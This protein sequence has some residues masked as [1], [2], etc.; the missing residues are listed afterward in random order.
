MT[1]ELAKFT[2]ARR[3]GCTARRHPHRHAPQALH[4]AE[5]PA[6]AWSSCPAPTTCPARRQPPARGR[7][8]EFVT[9]GPVGGWSR[10]ALRTSSATSATRPA[11]RRGLATRAGASLLGAHDRASNVDAPATAAGAVKEHRRRVLADVR[12]PAV[13]RGALRARPRR[14]AR[15]SGQSRMR[16]GLHA[17]E[18]E[19]IGDDIGGNG[20]PHRRAPVRDGGAGR[21]HGVGETVYGPSVGSD[22][23]FRDHGMHELKAL[24]RA[25]ADLRSRSR[26]RER[27]RSSGQ[28]RRPRQSGRAAGHVQD[29]PL[30]RQ[31]ARAPTGREPCA[32]ALAAPPAGT[33]AA[34]HRVARRGRGLRADRHAGEHTAAPSLR[35]APAPT[36]TAATCDDW[37]RVGVSGSA[38]AGSSGSRSPV[39]EPTSSPSST[40]PARTTPCRTRA[41]ERCAGRTR[42]VRAGAGR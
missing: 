15:G 10:G 16:V 36:L 13:G 33:S 34:G 32:G 30:A 2:Q 38:G 24:L 19:L 25:L 42:R 12:R 11:S 18:S 6:R 28:S 40:P 8:A 3:F 4:G 31:A 17:G 1:A 26:E 22:L 29:D 20:G 9:G 41:E 23:A 7:D 27:P 5:D 37:A 14:A 21:R 39:A 35:I